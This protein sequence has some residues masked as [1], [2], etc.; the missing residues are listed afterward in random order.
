MNKCLLPLLLL[1]TQL[2]ACGYGWQREGNQY[3][4]SSANRETVAGGR[5]TSPLMPDE[6]IVQPG[7]TVSAIAAR[8]N[9][10]AQDL[11]G[12][13]NLGQDYAI[14]PGQLLRLSPPTYRNPV[15]AAAGTVAYPTA[16]SSGMQG[17]ALPTAAP[18]GRP[19][20]LGA[21]T[22]ITAAPA[23]PAAPQP[24]TQGRAGVGYSAI[25]P[26]AVPIIAPSTRAAPP[27]A[28][29]RPMVVMPAP[30]PTP[31]APPA[32]LP[33]V[34]QV[35]RPAAPAA[36]QAVS[37]KGWRWPVTGTVVKS[38]APSNGSKGIDVSVDLGTPVRAA[39][40]GRVAYSGSALKGYG[41]LIVIKHDEVYLTAY[42]Y[43]RKRLVKEGEQV[44]AGQV[45][46]ESGIGP[47]Q[48]TVLHFEIRE[49]GNPVDPIPYLP[50]Q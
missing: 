1:S 18:L 22:P 33:P 28:P 50:G 32:T 40:A 16:E 47:E 19:V 26:S 3:P 27:P 24:A 23:A 29:A 31:V 36:S 34:Q 39:A 20:P 15:S 46:A 10:N 7:D 13:N 6:Y 25:A 5:I 8:K 38:Y 17:V 41:E 14:V 35:A 2:A 42:G 12:W 30:A 43:N 37:E 49:N 48:N 44:K 21:P 11:A 9:L 4:P 45:I